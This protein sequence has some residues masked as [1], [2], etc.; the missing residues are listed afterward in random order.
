MTKK[1][2]NDIAAILKDQYDW[3]GPN[4]Q[5]GEVITDI[6]DGLCGVFSADNPRFD[7]K[8]FKAAIYE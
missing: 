4:Q 5:A 2:Y 8:R 3:Y 1:D 6:V 7:C